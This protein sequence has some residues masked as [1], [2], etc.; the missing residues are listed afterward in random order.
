[1]KLNRDY[2]LTVGCGPYGPPS[3]TGGAAQYIS[4]AQNAVVIKPPITLEF[5]IRREF[6][7]S[8]QTATFRIKNLG[9]KTQDTIYKDRFATSLFAR[10]ALQAGYQGAFLPTIFD[11]SIWFARSNRQSRRDIVTEIDS[12]DGGFAMANSFSSFSLPPSNTYVDAL[13]RLNGDLVQTS[14][15]PIIGTVPGTLGPRSAIFV[16]PTFD[17]ITKL[18]PPGVTSTIDLGQLKVLADLDVLSFGSQTYLISANTGLLDPPVREGAFITV[19]MMF[20]PRITLGQVVQLDSV[21][22]SIFNGLYQVRGVSHSGIISGSEG[23]P[24]ETRL[25]LYLG[26]GLLNVLSGSTP[27]T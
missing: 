19:R 7:A 8:A 6:L 20:E 21:V 1:M 10:V 25:Q 5:E 26:P 14:A 27:S 9:E 24:A 15:T 22:N 3:A 4:V 16:G 17:L 12:F 2:V 13:Q 18:L 11:G 23:G